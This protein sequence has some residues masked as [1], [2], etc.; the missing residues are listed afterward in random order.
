MWDKPEGKTKEEKEDVS[1]ES[2]RRMWN[3]RGRRRT[4][5][6]RSGG[7]KVSFREISQVDQSF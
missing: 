7:Q 1:K 2:S 5:K 3:M 4:G 6:V